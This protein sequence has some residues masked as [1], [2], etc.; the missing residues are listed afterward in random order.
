MEFPTTDEWLTP[1]ET[2]Q[3]TKL[4]VKTLSNKRYDGSGPAYSKTA[5]GRGG[6]VRYRR[7]SVTAWLNAGQVTQP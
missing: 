3:M 2:S 5:P 6:R 1:Q 7:S 4:A